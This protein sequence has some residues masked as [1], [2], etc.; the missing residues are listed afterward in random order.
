MRNLRKLEKN[1]ADV[2]LLDSFLIAD[3]PENYHQN[4]W[5][6]D[7]FL[8]KI[9]EIFRIKLQ[10]CEK[11]FDEIWL[12]FWMLSGAEVCK[13]CRSRQELSNEYLVFTCNISRRYSRE[14]ASQSLPNISQKLENKLEET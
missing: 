13:S 5:I 7:S 4:L 3:I 6:M 14:Q 11:K 2:G 10:K 1:L 12:I 9:S 8:E